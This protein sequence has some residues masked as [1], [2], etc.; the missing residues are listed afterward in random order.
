VSIEMTDD[1]G[2]RLAG[3][4]RGIWPAAVL[5]AAVRLDV[6]AQLEGGER[7][8][9]EIAAALATDPDATARLLDALAAMGI[10]HKSGAR[11]RNGSAAA[12]HLVPGKQG[13]VTPSI[14]HLGNMWASWS[15]LPQVV[16]DG[17][18]GAE[19]PR[20]RTPE[21][22]ARAMRAGGQRFA[23]EL[24][25]ELDLTQ[26]SRAL[27][28]AGGPGTYCLAMLRAKPDLEVTLF[29]RPQI[30]ET[31]RKLLAES[32]LGAR[33]RLLEGDMRSDEIGSG[34]QLVLLSQVLH[35]YGPDTCRA[36]VAKAARA[37]APGGSLVIHEFALDESRT[38]PLD[39]ALFSINMLV[40]TEDG[41]A[42]TL[43]ELESFLTEA[44]LRVDRVIDLSGSTKA[45]VGRK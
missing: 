10:I 17:R 30:M 26:V 3:I 14:L 4:V 28:L 45:V 40:N 42:Y 21:N 34:Y 37:L 22:F 16:R 18:P 32:E 9:D 24:I 44:D 27:D 8:A 12:A 33:V 5:E 38:S 2:S 6:F 35:A 36:I 39:A 7:T 29:D 19:C 13:D 41:R 31:S 15:A 23:D 25:A 11:Y 20:E 1:D 43:S